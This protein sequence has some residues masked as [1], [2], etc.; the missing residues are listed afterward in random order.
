VR[1]Y[2]AASIV[3]LASAAAIS[4]VG[5]ALADETDASQPGHGDASQLL[6]GV[7]DNLYGHDFVQ[8]IRISSR[9]GDGQSITRR[10]Q[11]A[12][13]Q[14]PAPGRALIR[15]L[16]PDELR[17]TS[18]LI[19]GRADRDDDVFL[20]LPAFGFVRRVSSSQRSD[21]FFGTDLSFEDLEPK[22]IEDFDVQLG[23]PDRWRDIPCTRVETR[24]HRDVGSAYELV[25]L[26]LEEERP[27][28]LWAA[29]YQQGQLTKRLEVDPTSVREVGPT[30]IAHRARV[31]QPQRGS[32]S[33]LEI[34][35]YVV[36]EALPDHLF[37]VRNLEFGDPARDRREALSARDARSLLRSP[38]TGLDVGPKQHVDG[39][40]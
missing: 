8:T 26:C 17:R 20:Y 19:A 28:I 39:L 34:E 5:F 4:A 9:F 25:E 1:A 35:T 32:E 31:L 10:M 2:V 3:V 38:H 13:Q 24:P 11:V 23:G 6:S 15:L 30:W 40:R 37:S 18:I 29:F 16:A 22:R 33:L 36:Y 7:Y 27:V 14:A 12:R 21:A